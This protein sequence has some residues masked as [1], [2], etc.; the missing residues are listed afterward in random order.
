MMARRRWGWV[1][2]PSLVRPTL[3]YI[4]SQAVIPVPVFTR[5][6]SSGN[7]IQKYW[8]P[9]QARNDNQNKGTFDAVH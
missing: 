5:I 1:I 8:I 2:Q 9:G 4:S 3:L 7:P 6:N